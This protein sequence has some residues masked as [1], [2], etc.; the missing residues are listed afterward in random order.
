MADGDFVKVA[1]VSELSPGDIKPVEVGEDQILLCNVEGAI[2]AIDDI[3][4]HSYA[5]LSEGDLY[6]DEIV[7]PLHGALFNVTTGA[8]ITHTADQ[9]LRVFQVRV[10]GDDILVGP[11]A[12]PGAE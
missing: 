11:Q 1:E 9:P 8:V 6:G 4:T 10:E 3:C 5:S 12:E 7:C 2:H